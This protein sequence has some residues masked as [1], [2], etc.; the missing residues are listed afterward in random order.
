MKHHI[1]ASDEAEWT[2][3][4][5]YWAHVQQFKPRRGSVVGHVTA[6]MIA[7][8]IAAALVGMGL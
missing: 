7:G 8:V 5:R 3:A 2:G 6:I 4:A 1:I